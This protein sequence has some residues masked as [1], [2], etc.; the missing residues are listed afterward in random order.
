M[1]EP[2]SLLEF[3]NPLVERCGVIL[4]DD[5]IIEI[6]NTHSEPSDNFSFSKE[7]FEKY[8][9]CVAT[10]HTHPSGEANLSV[11]DYNTFLKNPKFFNYIVG[12]GIVWGFYV[13]DNRVYLYE[14]G[15][16]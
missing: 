14:D 9:N 15:D 1:F 4:A 6:P 8:P 7:Q 11:N 10:W 12:N 2:N 5:S 13:R 16:F 3:W